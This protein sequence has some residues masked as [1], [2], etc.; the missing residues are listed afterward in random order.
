[1]TE[2]TASLVVVAA[3]EGLRLEAGLHKALAPLKGRPIVEHC[4]RHLLPLTFLD[5][6]ILVGHP[7]DR[8]ALQSLI[9]DLPR[10]VQL[11]DGGARRQDSVRAGVEACPEDPAIVLVHDAARPFPPLEAMETLIASASRTGCA[12]LATPVADTLK[13]EEDGKVSHTVPR[14]DLWAAQTPQACHRNQLLERLGQADETGIE[15]T[16]EASLFEQP[17]DE[18][19]LVPG[20]PN[21]VKIT[22]MADLDLVASQLTAAQEPSL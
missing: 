19:C 14:T 12:L 17:G 9:E 5:P 21:N 20:S 16:D 8:Q 1:M 6:V 18:V 11:V 13:A 15:V 7:D 3:G 10:D 4:L 2:T 22:T